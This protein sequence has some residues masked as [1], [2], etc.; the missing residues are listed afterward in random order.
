MEAKDKI[1]K[2]LPNALIGWYPFR[3]Q[4][5]V[6]FLWDEGAEAGELCEFLEQKGVAL[7]CCTE[8]ELQHKKE[9]YDCILLVGSIERSR[10]PERLLSEC[11]KHLAPAGRLLL[12]ANN[13]L[14]IRFFC[15]DQDL[16]T[17]HVL[18]GLDH[19]AKV[20]PKRREKLAGR[21]Y[22]K[23]ELQ[24][25][26]SQ[27][28]FLRQRCYSVMPSLDRPQILLAE[29]Y[30]PNEALEIRIFP[31]Y[32]NP[33]TVFLEEEKLY[34]DLL[35]NGLFHAMANGFLIECTVE[36]ELTD[37]DQITLSGD[38]GHENA[39][40]TLIRK[41]VSV[42]K[43]ALYPEGEGRLEELFAN[44]R[45]LQERGIPVAGVKQEENALVMPY[46]EG[47]LATLYFRKLLRQDREAFL[48]KLE[49]FRSLITASSEPV[50]YEKVN[51][52]HFDPGWD[53][54]KADDPNLHKWRELALGTEEKQKNI[55][56]ILKRGYMDLVSL[57]CFH[58]KQ[59]FL[60]FDQEFYVEDL[61]AN[62]IFLRT[63]DLIYQDDPLLEE[64]LSRDEVLKHFSLYEHRELWRRYTG[65]FMRKL[66]SEKALSV[67]HKRVRRDNRVVAAN[68]HRMDYTQEE[69]ERLFTDIFRNTGGKGIFLFGAGRFAE[70]FI[71]QFGEFYR[72]TG[73]VDNDPEKWGTSLQGI[74]ILAPQVLGEA[75]QPFQVFVC[76]K[77]YDGILEQ[78]REM[79][80]TDISVYNPAVEY[81]RPLKHTAAVQA[82]EKKRYP[83]GYVAGV[84]DLFHIG[85]L[86]LLQRAKEQ[87][88]Y[89][90][91]GV[92]SDEQVI[93]DKRTSPYV[94][95]AERKRIVEA[96]RYVDEVVEIPA[97][98]PGTEAAYRKYH[99]DAQFSGSDYA[100][101]PGWLA[102]K[103]FLKQ[104]G[105][106]LV[107]FPYTESTS[108]TKLKEK[109]R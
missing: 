22:S 27:A 69:Y 59:G 100:E 23:A 89:L 105:A 106:D 2:E 34:G 67:Y 3:K 28:G 36:G 60:F 68:R 17:G 44:T 98:D 24:G 97:E 95:F 63:I 92:V 91:V 40:A 72:I 108:S 55:G 93:R 53:S 50:P 66:R 80:I 14:G 101:D 6:L 21:A 37:A 90:I 25:F 10:H 78:L 99:F 41:D 76:V 73:I 86:N 107:F 54:R 26:L 39:L 18:D 81:R 49:E 46:V 103:E 7:T 43:Q 83:V 32:K 102:K 9:R 79:G 35:K 96:C 1:E 85:H 62:V 47:E 12:G 13:R 65:F 33:R 29:G 82:G 42:S 15:G 71:S 11:R 64:L 45:Y 48:Q 8:E 74:P 52:E 57:N 104:H 5:Q 87:C 16:Y 56:V 19:Y 30:I 84:F 109:L 38:R 88:G 61:P 70:Q 31:Q 75:E 51:W 77:F 20:S 58:T 94:P 4:E